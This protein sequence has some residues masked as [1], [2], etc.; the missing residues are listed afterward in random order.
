MRTG[1]AGRGRRL[2]RAAR[3]RP[4]RRGARAVRRAGRRRGGDLDAR[5]R[6]VRLE[7]RRPRADPARHRRGHPRRGLRRAGPARH[8]RRATPRPSGAPSAGSAPT[9][10]AG[11]AAASRWPRRSARCWPATRSPS[12]PPSSCACRPAG[13]PRPVQARIPLTVGTANSTLLRWA[14]A[15]ADVVGLTGFGRTLADG[16]QPRGA[17]AGRPDRGAA[18]AASRPA[19]PAGT[20]PPALEALVQHVAVTDDAEAAAA[21]GRGDR[22]DR[23]RAA[24]HAVRADRH[25]WTRSSRRWR[26]TTP[27]G[28]H[29]LRGTAGALDPLAP[30][31]P[32]LAGKELDFEHARQ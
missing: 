12:T 9:S 10:P 23:R 15:H 27:L 8:R 17:L 26:R 3:R 24:G 22:P 1:P 21:S 2:R 14:G 28:R 11:Y 31:L 19:R 30:L 6:L 18:R 29:P 20:T 25:A 16:H 4:P 13:S 7:R 5:A 32:R